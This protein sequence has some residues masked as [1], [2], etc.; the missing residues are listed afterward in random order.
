MTGPFS[1]L[2]VGRLYAFYVSWM[3]KHPE[4]LIAFVIDYKVMNDQAIQIIECQRIGSQCD[5][6]NSKPFVSCRKMNSYCS[7]TLLLLKIKK[8]ESSSRRQLKNALAWR[9][10]W[11]E[12]KCL[13]ILN[14]FLIRCWVVLNI[15]I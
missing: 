6:I 5:V 2:N 12:R 9:E 1:V 7:G 4:F 13:Y 3:V 8:I 14:S 10:I 11:I 15:A